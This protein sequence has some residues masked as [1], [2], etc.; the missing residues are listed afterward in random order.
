MSPESRSHNET[1][2]SRFIEQACWNGARPVRPLDMVV[3]PE[4]AHAVDQ[5]GQPVAAPVKRERAQIL[6]VHAEKV[7]GDQAG[8]SELLSWPHG[9]ELRPAVVKQADRLAVEN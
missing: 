7:V 8:V 5:R 3:E 4:S 1:I 9:V 2:P 6:A